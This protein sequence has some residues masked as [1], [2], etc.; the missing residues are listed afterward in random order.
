MT[1]ANALTLLRLCL[2]PLIVVMIFEGR[3]DWA[4]IIFITAA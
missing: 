1:I 4:T 3:F 2:I